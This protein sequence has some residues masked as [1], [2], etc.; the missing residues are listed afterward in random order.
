LLLGLVDPE[1]RQILAEIME[2]TLL[3]LELLLRVAEVLTLTMVAVL[4]EAQ[5]A[6]L[7]DVVLAHQ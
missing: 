2:K 1:E 5:V 4:L 3:L 6:E 7:R